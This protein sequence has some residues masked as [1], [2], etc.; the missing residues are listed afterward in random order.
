M[1]WLSRERGGEGWVMKKLLLDS[2]IYGELAVDKELDHLQEKFEQ[3]EGIIVY[4]FSLIRKELRATSKEKRHFGKNLRV[5]ML[6]LYDRFVKDKTLMVDEEKVSGIA[7][8]YYDAYRQLGGGHGKAE[9][10]N[11]YLVVACASLKGMDIVAS[12]DHATMLSEN[13]LRAYALVNQALQLKN[14]KFIDYQHF[15]VFLLRNGD[16]YGSE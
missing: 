11:D 8:K 3:V 14:P 9:L 13:S 6:S 15:K 16:L 4:G 2:C 10:W 12:N 7:Q 5:A 1:G